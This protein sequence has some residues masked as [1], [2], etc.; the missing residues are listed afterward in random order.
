MKLT[1]DQYH[2]IHK[3]IDKL[4]QAVINNKIIHIKEDFN[5]HEL[6][7]LLNMNKEDYY[8]N[9]GNPTLLLYVSEKLNQMLT[10]Q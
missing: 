5:E 2:I 6:D 9:C 10:L 3:L 4:N 8:D 1:K 7:F